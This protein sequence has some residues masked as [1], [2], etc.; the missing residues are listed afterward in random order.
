MKSLILPITLLLFV[1][2]SFAQVN[3]EKRIE[4]DLKDEFGGHS[5]RL[6]G[7]DGFV[8]RSVSNKTKG[9]RDFKYELYSTELSIKNEHIENVAIGKIQVFKSFETSTH[10]IDLLYE[11]SGAA[12]LISVEGKSLKT[13]KM[14]INLPPQMYT[15]SGEATD[16][17]IFLH[18]RIKKNVVVFVI[19]WRTGKSQLIPLTVGAY[20]STQLAIDDISLLSNGR[21]AIYSIKAVKGKKMERFL[22][23][24]DA[25]DGSKKQ[26]NISA[27]LE[28]FLVSVSATESDKGTYLIT[29]TYSSKLGG[30]SEGLYF[31]QMVGEKIKFINYHN[32]TKLENFFK[33]LPQKKQDKIEKKKG[34]AA[35][36]GKELVLNYYIATHDLIKFENYYY[37]LGEAYYPTYRTE[38]YTTYVNGKPVTQTRTVFDGYQYTH[39]TLV[40]YNAKGEIIWDQTFEMWPSYKPF[41]VKRFIKVSE[42]VDKS[43]DMIFTSRSRIIS[44]SVGHKGDI[45]EERTSETLTTGIEGDVSKFTFSNVESWYDK[46]FIAFGSQTIKNKENED[47]KKKRTVFFI[48]KIKF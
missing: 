14:T 26:L 40:K 15:I 38:T 19:D 10:F 13:N 41:F 11:K 21:E 7:K 2:Q 32:F 25:K 6:F 30:S 20:K 44:K 17:Y 22:M 48:A 18:G 39:A 33:Y 31:A 45:L 3:V 5:V 34:K 35:S 24:V 36:S 8:I 28:K 29:G 4:F 47:V 9:F 42:N 37:F 46:Y 16:N 43:I 23:L 1:A 12:T 27:G